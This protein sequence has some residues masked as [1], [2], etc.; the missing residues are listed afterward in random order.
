M[1]NFRNRETLWA[2]L[3][4]AEL[5]QGELPA[6]GESPSPWYIK[7]L[8]AFSGWL[9]ALFLMGFLAVA[10]EMLWREP[11]TGLVVGLLMIASAYGL[12]RIP[13]NEFVAHL[14][15]AIS[16]AGQGWVVFSLFD[17][18]G[19]HPAGF[20]LLIGIL[21]VLLAW[22]M[23]N[24]IHRVFS[25][26][27]AALAF[28]VALASLHLPYLFSS[29]ILLGAAWLWLNE[30]RYPHH[31]QMVHA[32]GY[33]LVLALMILKGTTLFGQEMMI[34]HY[35][36][37]E[38]QPL[39]TPWMGEALNGLVALLIIWK[40]LQHYFT[41]LSQGAPLI[42]MIGMLV[43]CLVS[44]EAH[45]IAAGM[46]LLILGFGSS[47]RVLLGLG[48]ISLLFYISTYYYL[49]HTSLLHKSVSMLIIG[50]ALLAW[51]WALITFSPAFREQH[52]EQ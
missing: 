41:H 8:L 37:N 46:I 48:I 6:A 51:R 28:S 17:L 34:W 45:G 3:R 35:R 42:I 10:I 30:F 36:H 49:L 23:P 52:H 24:F 9:A 18:L 5:V 15:L 14:A 43:L 47:N 31:L 22:L 38:Q 20:W 25:S 33:G 50:I 11:V 44:L 21:Q 19:N 12:L 7:V 2:Q 4:A 26:G 40:L 27:A 13:R 1:T 39:T 29:A 32:L 16:L